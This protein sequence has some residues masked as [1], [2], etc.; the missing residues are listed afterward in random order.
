MAVT[1]S[2][3]N[4]LAVRL[5]RYTVLLAFSIGLL[6]ST[7]QLLDDYQDQEHRIDQTI[8][9]ILVVSTP[10]ATR[11]VTT[12]DNM[13]AEEVVSGLLKY[14]FIERA[15]ISDELGEILAHSKVELPDSTTLWLTN[16]LGL[17]H[18]EYRQPLQTP[19]YAGAGPGQ[20]VLQVNLDQ[21]FT[22]FYDR[23]LVIVLSGLT[24]NILLALLLL[25]IFYLV[26]TKPLERL[27]EQFSRVNLTGPAPGKPL[28]VAERHRHDELG[29]LCNTGN[30]LIQTLTGLLADKDQAGQ[31]LKNSEM[32]LLKLIDR[33]PQMIIA[34][35]KSG[36]ILFSNQQFADFYQRNIADICTLTVPQLHSH[37]PEEANNIEM[38]RQSVLANGEV[39]NLSEIAMSDPG[40]KQ[41]YF[42]LQIAPFEYFTEPATIIVA[43]NITEQRQI[44]QHIAKLATHDSLTGLPNRMLLNDRLELSLANCQ[45]NHQHN[46]LL[47]LDLDHFKN[48]NDSLGHGVGDQLLIEVSKRLT[49]MVRQN[50]TVARLGGDEF[51]ILL[52]ELPE[53]REAAH[54]YV[55]R[56]GD[57]LQEQLSQP[58]HVEDRALHVGV[59]IGVVLFPMQDKTQTDLLRYADTAMY[60][61]KA[62]GR[63]QTVFYQE[64][65]SVVVEQ[66]HDLE[67]EL[68]QALKLEQYLVHYQPQV[69]NKGNIQA[70][71]ALIRWQHPQR[72]LVPPGEFISI[73][74]S[75][76]L[77]VP[78][79]EWLIKHCCAQINEWRRSGYWQPHWHVAIN[80]SPLLFYQS[81]FVDS[82]EREITAA[83]L[84]FDDICIEI[85]ESLAL[86]NIDFATQRLDQIRRL[87]MPIAMDDFGTG[88]SSLSYLKNL[89]IDILKIDRSFVNELGHSAKEQS[90][91]EA[92]IAMAKILDLNVIAE[93]VETAQQLEILDRLGCGCYQ[94]FYF[95]RPQPAAALPCEAAN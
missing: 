89:P 41:E 12:L 83:R 74:E 61:A 4:R 50:D 36:K 26:L 68:H 62:K 5:A 40:G 71:E 67:N 95:C 84:P 64:D 86:D 33:V 28:M 2:L 10:P 6:L 85:T 82:L 81:G 29:Q 24:R 92:I 43:S 21:A 60:Q 80:I 19:E 8:Q 18:K 63:K 70:F 13:L 48:I 3:K 72:G 38:I 15:Q 44:Q 91:V 76:G 55:A 77:I 94:G 57:K 51:V 53:D 25:V 31:A 22:D 47:F 69:D 11:A 9:Q 27:A 79:S 39:V 73:L 78:V 56:I 65:M 49:G 66:L 30:E 45:R 34:Q 7:L 17:T 42:S 14:P 16:A 59:S 20:L 54:D 75:S 1:I 58:I 32:R 37:A 88:Y 35:N 23:S 87:G 93:G 90:I 52:Q 46:A